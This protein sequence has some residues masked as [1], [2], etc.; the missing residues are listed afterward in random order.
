MAKCFRDLT[1][2]QK[3]IRLTVLVYQLSKGFPRE[4]IYGLTSQMRRAAVSIPSNIAEG[5]GRLNTP[6]YRQFLGIARASSF[7]LL[8]HLAIAKELGFGQAEQIAAA[9]NLCNELG[10][11]ILALISAIQEENR[12][13]A[14]D[15]FSLINGQPVLH[16]PHFTLH[17]R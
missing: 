13:P 1:V 16:T 3:G 14:S 7:E 12:P 4:E 17:T 6:E 8:T 15:T 10:R 5:A 9:D 11:M 2:W